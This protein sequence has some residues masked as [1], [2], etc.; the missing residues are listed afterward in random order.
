[1]NGNFNTSA[2]EK[3]LPDILDYNLKVLFI[4]FNPGVLS[5]KTKHHYANKSNRFWRLLYESGLTPYRLDPVDDVKLLE[6][7]YGSTNIVDSVT[8][9]ASEI[10][11]NEYKKGSFELFE[12]IKVLKPWIVCYV[13]IGVYREYASAILNVSKNALKFNTGLQERSIIPEIMDFVCSNPSGL[14]TIQYSAQ[15]ECFAYLK[16]LIDAL[17]KERG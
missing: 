4:G 10:P 9:L 1:M 7:G 15:V 3:N 17:T 16:K 14:N 12:L 6:Y 2:A 11:A 5:A 13:G 8:R